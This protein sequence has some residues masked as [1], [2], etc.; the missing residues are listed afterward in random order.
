MNSLTL[1][2]PRHR[3]K[4]IGLIAP[5][6]NVPLKKVE[7]AVAFLE[8]KGFRVFRDACQRKRHGYLAGTDRERLSCL[9]EFW[10]NQEVDLLLSVRGGY[11]TARLLSLLPWRELAAKPKLLLG[12]SDL[13]AL[14]NALLCRSGLVSVSSPMAATELYQQPDS[15]TW[16]SLEPFLRSGVTLENSQRLALTSDMVLHPGRG[17]GF[18]LGGN[19]SV[20][21]SLM[22]TPYLRRPRKYVLL[23]E[24][25]GEYPF[26]LDRYFRMLVNGGWL[27][28]AAGVLLGYFRNCEEPD[29]Q[30]ATFTAGELLQEYF[31]NLPVPVIRNLPYGHD[32]P[33]LSLPIG[34]WV[35]LDTE[36][37]VLE[38]GAKQPSELEWS[39]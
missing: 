28:N 13:T 11:G 6:G 7:Q 18:L 39:S 32:E 37:G 35:D 1:H 27:Q 2:Y 33:K 22:G 10:Q 30:K 4:T 12:Y 14:Q 19:L 36:H 16:N 5:A 26:R 31:G 9:L 8:S 23:L 20:F 17:A 3:G 34:G 25:H 15:L 29:A 38:V 24:D 21:T